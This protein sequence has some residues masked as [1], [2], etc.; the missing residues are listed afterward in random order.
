MFSNKLKNDIGMKQLLLAGFVGVSCI[1]GTYAQK[2]EK[3]NIIFVISDDLRPELNCYGQSHMKTP[4][5]D[6][7][8]QEGVTFTN[9]FVQQAICSASRASFLTGC[10]PD[11]TGVDYPYSEYFVN[12]FMPEHPN[13]QAHM[14]KSGYYVRNFGK[15]HHGLYEDY[16]EH[17]FLA[18]SV[19]KL[20][21]TQKNIDIAHD[22]S[23]APPFECADVPDDKYADGV[24]ANEVI[25]TIR[26]VGQNEDQPFFLTVGFYKPHLPFCAPKKYWDLYDRDSIPLSQNPEPATGSPK[27]ATTDQALKKWNGESDAKGHIVSEERSRLLK[28]AYFACVS[29]VDT[30]LGKIIT[31]L[32]EQKLYENTIIVFVSDHGWHL[33]D[34][35][36]WGKATNFERAT[37]APLIVRFPN[38]EQNGVK[39]D[40]LVE[41]VDLF[42]SLVDFAGI[43]IPEYIE[44]TSFSPLLKDPERL[45]KKAAFSQYP[46]GNNEGYSIRT[47]RYRYTE[48]RNKEGRIV[49]RELYDHFN[50]SN[51]TVNIVTD[52]EVLVQSLSQQLKMGWKKALPDGVI[53][54]SDN[55]VAPD[56]VPWRRFKGKFGKRKKNR[57]KKVDIVSSLP[58]HDLMEEARL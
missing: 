15:V 5:L 30:Q 1:N 42:P 33:G 54:V 12:E 32:K 10:R 37:R 39:C 19:H 24:V 34:H 23:V 55:P 14:H 50:D 38:S 44:G 53:N 58:L 56:A 35:G 8:A 11:V 17:H 21:A 13:I 31:E 22:R 57:K 3:P 25:K 41:Y 2:N 36:M 48:W 52:N 26:K 7:L 29:Y 43:E 9:A 16:S 49:A 28:H 45:W 40:R 27:Y 6:A 4:V 18:K 51:E 47:E 20:Y 46:R